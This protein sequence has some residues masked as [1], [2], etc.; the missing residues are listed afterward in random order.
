MGSSSIEVQTNLEIS[1]TQKSCLVKNLY[2]RAYS[3]SQKMK[4]VAFVIN[5]KEQANL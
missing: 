4:R 5:I 2:E 3:S 1:S